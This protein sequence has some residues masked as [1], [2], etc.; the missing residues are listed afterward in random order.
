VCFFV[1]TFGLRLGWGCFFFKWRSALRYEH[2][3]YAMGW[4]LA[5]G[6]GYC[7]YPCTIKLGVY[8]FEIQ[9]YISLIFLLPVFESPLHAVPTYENMSFISPSRAVVPVIHLALRST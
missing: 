4:S 9:V 1:F 7:I 8:E 5:I 6:L 3:R 2:E